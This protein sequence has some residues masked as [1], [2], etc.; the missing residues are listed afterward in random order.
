MK[1]KS[2]VITGIGIVCALGNNKEEVKEGLFQNANKMRKVSE[3]GDYGQLND[4]LIGLCHVDEPEINSEKDY[5]KS[6]IMARMAIREACE[7]SGIENCDFSEYEDRAALSLAT[8]LM[9]SEFLI[10]YEHNG[11]NSTEWLIHSKE[12]AV[13]FAEEYNVYG[14]V[15]TTSSACASGSAGIGIAYDLV[16]SGESDIVLCGGTDHISEISLNGFYLLG[17]LSKGRCKPFDKER[18]GINIG[19]GSAFF[20]IEEYEHAI[21]RNAKIYGH[22]MGYGLANDAY[23]ITSPDPSG[24]G[25][26]HSMKLALKDGYPEGLYVNT[27]GTGTAANDSMELKA[28]T[29]YFGDTPVL[30][31]STKALT[32]HCL[33][34]AGSIEMVFS[35]LFMEEGTM[36][37]TGNSSFDAVESES[38]TDKIT[39]NYHIDSILSNSFAFGGND[40]SVWVKK[41][42]D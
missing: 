29:N 19:E 16:S 41:G 37:F 6:E 12:Y 30:M 7:D 36:P 23:H 4:F 15:Y 8:S 38:I 26:F 14:G 3:K 34:A 21:K 27:H 40:A 5:D 31:S 25:A 32:G 11:R 2:V 39:E 1:K 35:L 10:K 24:D 33:G 20:I 42:F 18:D 28:V 9:G 13:R 22:I 17:T